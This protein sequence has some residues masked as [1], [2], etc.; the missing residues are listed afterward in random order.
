MAPRTSDSD[1]F[2]SI[3][4]SQIKNIVNRTKDHEFRK[5]GLLPNTIRIW[6]YETAPKS[7][8]K[9]MAA[10]SSAKRPGKDS[11]DDQGL[12]N[13][14]F[15]ARPDGSAEYAYEILDLYKLANPV[16]F[17]EIKQRGWFK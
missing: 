7:R 13:A 14:E 10:I 12:G 9:Y 17:A 1:V 11:L 16:S 15:N 6:I 5:W 3:H 2:I 4:P 8:V